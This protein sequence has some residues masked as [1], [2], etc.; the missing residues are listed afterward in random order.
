MLVKA[1]QTVAFR[2]LF[3]VKKRKPFRKPKNDIEVRYYY[4]HFEVICDESEVKAK[5]TEQ[6][7]EKLSKMR[8]EGEVYQYI[9]SGYTT[10]IP[11]NET[12]D[13]PNGRKFK[14]KIIYY[15]DLPIESVAKELTSEMFRR[16]WQELKENADCKLDE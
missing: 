3:S 8:K 4:Y 5:L 1:K 11:P 2:T 12:N 7:E 15:K 16:F 6:I 10:E 13:Y 9:I 14:T